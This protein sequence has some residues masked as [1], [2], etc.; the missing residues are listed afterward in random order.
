[1]EYLFGLMDLGSALYL[2]GPGFGYL[3]QVSI[4]SSDMIITGASITQEPQQDRTK[5]KRE[6]SDKKSIDSEI[7]H[8]KY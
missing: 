4:N 7:Q 3:F 8:K 5:G 1:M 6:T 2:G